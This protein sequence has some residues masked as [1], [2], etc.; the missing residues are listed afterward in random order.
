MFLVFTL[1]IYHLRECIRDLYSNLVYRAILSCDRYF[2][3]LINNI[4][5]IPRAGEHSQEN[6]NGRYS[7]DLQKKKA[8]YQLNSMFGLV[9]FPSF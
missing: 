2:I 3:S 9:S 6:Q 8:K 7:L 5:V 4:D 1:D